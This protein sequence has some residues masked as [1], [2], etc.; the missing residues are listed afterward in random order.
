MLNQLTLGMSSD[1]MLRRYIFERL[2]KI[3]LG[4]IARKRTQ[5][6]NCGLYVVIGRFQ[7][8]SGDGSRSVWRKTKSGDP[9]KPGSRLYN[10]QGRVT[11]TVYQAMCKYRDWLEDK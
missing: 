8:V 11:Y 2:F 5:L 6:N 7:I 3:Q 9:Q 4:E 1:N 10:V